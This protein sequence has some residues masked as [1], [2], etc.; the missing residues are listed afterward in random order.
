MAGTTRRSDTGTDAPKVTKAV[1]S[2]ESVAD[3]RDVSPRAKVDTSGSRIKAIT[4][5]GGT[6][7]VIREKDFLKGGIKHPEVIWHF[8][9]NGFT[10]KVGEGITKQ[11]AD[12]LVKNFPTQFKYVGEK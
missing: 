11:A 3:S 1:E 7:V 4:F 12:Y 10:V 2:L 6:Q 8:Q 9:I 5:S